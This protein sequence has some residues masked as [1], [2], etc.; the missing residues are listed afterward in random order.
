MEVLLRG[1]N[2]GPFTRDWNVTALKRPQMLQSKSISRHQ[3]FFKKQNI[4]DPPPPHS[5]LRKGPRDLKRNGD[6]IKHETDG[7]EF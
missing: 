2:R 1:D 5:F 6:I 4:R 7:S 3:T